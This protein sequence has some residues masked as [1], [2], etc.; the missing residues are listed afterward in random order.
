MHTVRFC[1]QICAY[2]QTRP[3]ATEFIASVQNSLSRW[4]S[5]HSVTIGH[6]W[7]KL[8]IPRACNPWAQGV[9]GSNPIAPTIFLPLVGSAQ[10]SPSHRTA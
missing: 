1:A 4:H 5:A 3:S 7:C 8:L 2:R 10:L 6:N 9:I